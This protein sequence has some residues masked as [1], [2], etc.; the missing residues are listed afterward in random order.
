MDGVR[1]AS[2]RLRRIRADSRVEGGAGSICSRSTENLFGYNIGG[3][4]IGF[5]SRSTGVR[6]DLRYYSTVHGSD[7]GP[8]A[9]GDVHLRYMTASVGVVIRR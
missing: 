8:I 9:I 6:F 4:A 5:F 3:G 7:H 1:P 2:I